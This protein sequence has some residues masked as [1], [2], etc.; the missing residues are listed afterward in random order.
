MTIIIR[1]QEKTVEGGCRERRP[2]RRQGCEIDDSRFCEENRLLVCALL[3][4]TEI[5]YLGTVLP[6]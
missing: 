2:T 4:T 6:P 1:K 5:V 3:P